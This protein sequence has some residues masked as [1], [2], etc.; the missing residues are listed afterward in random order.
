MVE[1][2]KRD[3]LEIKEKGSVRSQRVSKMT[4]VQ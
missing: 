1:M 2:V 3:R 4:K